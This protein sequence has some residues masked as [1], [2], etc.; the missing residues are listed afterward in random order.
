MYTAQDLVDH[1]LTS[2]GGGAQDGE[3]RAVR[4][5]VV[6]GI[7]EVFQVRNWLWNVKTGSF[8][9]GE[10]Q[11]TATMTFPSNSDIITVSP[12]N[13]GFVVGRLVAF[14]DGSFFDYTPRIVAL[15]SSTTVRLDRSAVKAGTSTVRAQT[16]YDLPENVRDLDALVTETVGTLHHYVT[17]MEW[18]RLEVNTKGAGQPFYYTIMKSDVNPDRYQVR[19]VGIPTDG[20][21]VFYT[22]R[23]NPDPAKLMGY[24][25][26]CRAGTAS[27]AASSTTV[28]FTGTTLPPDLSDAV[29]R[30]GTAA[31]IPEP[32]GSM[33]PYVYERRITNRIDNNSVTIDSPLPAAV[34]SVKYTISDLIDCSPQMW[35][36][37]LSATEMW[38]ARMAGKPAVEV[39]Q[40]FNRDLRLALE[41]DVVAPMSGRPAPIMFPTP[42]SMGWRSAQLADQG[43]SKS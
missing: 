40:L 43:S 9:T 4:A 17:P 23:Y 42:R 7:R 24:E 14:G 32:I 28:T 8:T 30:F 25:P 22:Y 39:V 3:N 38:Y 31:N 12:N 27:V 20:T 6:H 35:T 21:I 19:F 18:L 11:A 13:T 29:I 41:A 36:A 2:T 15:P 1:L 34:T 16:Y 10:V 26:S 37:M 5:A 33:T